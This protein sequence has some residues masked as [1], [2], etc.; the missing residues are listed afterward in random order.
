MCLDWKSD[1]L[2]HVNESHTRRA[3]DDGIGR[4]G[5]ADAAQQRGNRYGRRRFAFSL[6]D[7]L[8]PFMADTL[9]VVEVVRVGILFRRTGFFQQSQ[10]VCEHGTDFSFDAK[11]DRV[12]LP[13]FVW[14]D[15]DLN[16]FCGC[17]SEGSVFAE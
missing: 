11:R 1:F 3:D 13:D 16:D 7:G 14:I 8:C 17:D 10:H 9:N 2:K 12:I 15:I 5:F 4:R 6:G